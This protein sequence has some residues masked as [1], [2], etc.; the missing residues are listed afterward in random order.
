M[1]DEELN[2]LVVERAQRQVEARKTLIVEEPRQLPARAERPGLWGLIALLLTATLGALLLLPGSFTERLG[3]VV[4]GVC[5]K[6]HT[7]VLGGVVLPLCQ[8]NTGIYAGFLATLITLILLGRGRAAKLPPL[9]ILILLGLNGAWMGVDGFNS[10][11]LDIGAGNLYPPQPVLRILSGLAM[12]MTVGTM[13]LF[14]FNITLRANPLRNQAIMGGWR[15]VAVVALVE[16]ALF[17][18]IRLAGPIIAYP[19]AIFSTIGILLVMFTVNLMVVAMIS[20]YEGMVTRV[21]QLARPAMFALVLTGIEFG[22]LAWGRV[23]LERSI[24]M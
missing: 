19:L 3:W 5:A 4:H 8:R 21:V 14:A 1:N 17:A 18:L 23:A 22:L 7:L 12:G 11:L 13:L 10:L 2:R 16:L 24:G 20:R 15:D 6:E 9:P